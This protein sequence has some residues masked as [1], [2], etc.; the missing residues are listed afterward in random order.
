MEMGKPLQDHPHMGCLHPTPTCPLN[1]FQIHESI[2][3]ALQ[4][5]KHPDLLRSDKFPCPVCSGL[6]RFGPNT[7]MISPVK[8]YLLQ[9]LHQDDPL[10]L[11]LGHQ[12][13]AAA[14]DG[15][16]EQ[17]PAPG[18]ILLV[19]AVGI[20]HP[21]VDLQQGCPLLLTHQLYQL[22]EGSVEPEGLSVEDEQAKYDASPPT[23]IQNQI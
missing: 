6:V 1:L 14:W 20:V 21:W 8:T 13:A 23:N 22:W 11:G 10:L 16:A 17:A 15:P 5:N 3:T 7:N 18:V 19:V 2:F 12:D 4:E 9:V